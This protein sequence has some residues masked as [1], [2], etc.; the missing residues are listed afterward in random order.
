MKYQP[1]VWLLNKA[2]KTN[3]GR[4][5][6]FLFG[7][8]GV[9]YCAWS[10]APQFETSDENE[11]SDSLWIEIYKRRIKLDFVTDSDSLSETDL[12]IEFENNKLFFA[13]QQVVYAPDVNFKIFT[14][15]VESC[16]AYC[17]SEYYS[18]IHYAINAENKT[19]KSNFTHIDSIYV[20][21]NKQYL[22]VD[23]YGARPASVL[24]IQCMSAH[25]FS[26]EKDTLI[27]NPIQYKN[28]NSFSFCQENSVFSSEPTFITYDDTQKAIL[29]SYTNNYAYSHNLDIDTIR[30][31]QFKYEEQRFVLDFET[32][33]T[34]RNDQ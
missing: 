25:L 2:S 21:P 15:E 24:T 28:D 16:G 8:I 14:I 31:G 20:L 26:L 5:F 9:V 13:N 22:I 11:V 29:Y 23:S 7:I 18:W 32:T 4:I 30:K 33:K 17:N 1:L 34:I 6:K 12:N 27:E 10:C 19:Q 3:I